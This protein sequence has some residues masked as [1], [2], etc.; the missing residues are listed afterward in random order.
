MKLT[1]KFAL[2]T[3]IPILALVASYYVSVQAMEQLAQNQVEQQARLVM[4]GRESRP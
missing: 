2:I 3:L 1:L 4:S